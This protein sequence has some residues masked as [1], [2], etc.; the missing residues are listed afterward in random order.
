MNEKIK[1]QVQLQTP[2]QK[3]ETLTKRLLAVPKK[4]INEKLAEFKARPRKKRVST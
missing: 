3:F 4:E 2:F 1:E